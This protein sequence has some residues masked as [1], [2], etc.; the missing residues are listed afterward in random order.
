MLARSS[1]RFETYLSEPIVCRSGTPRPSVRLGLSS[2]GGT[3]RQLSR[4][5]SSITPAQPQ[6]GVT[7]P[8][9]LVL[10][11]ES[12]ADDSCC[13][14]VSSDRQVL[15]N[16]VIKQHAI[17]AEFGGINPLLAQK[18]HE[19]NV[20]G[21]SDQAPRPRWVPAEGVELTFAAY[22]CGEGA[23]RGQVDNIRH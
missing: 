23:A 2:R 16:V 14:I 18:A 6:A 5:S 19:A 12:S 1:C 22:G 20:V 10:A 17:N 13:A 15:A 21:P 3:L 9:R 7:I 4:A 8:R 11:V